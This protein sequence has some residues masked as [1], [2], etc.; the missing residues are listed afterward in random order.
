M[1]LP[2]F[3]LVVDHQ[4]LVP[5]LNNYTLDA[6]ENPKLQRLK[7]RLSPYV[8]TTMWRKGREHAIPDALSRAPVND[9]AP[10]DEAANSDVKTCSQRT[11]INRIA[12]ISAES[13]RDTCITDAADVH[14]HL[15]DP[16]VEEIRAVAATDGDYTTELTELTTLNRAVLLFIVRGM[17]PLSLVDSCHFT[18]LVKALDPRIELPCRSTLTTVLLP[19]LYE[20]AKRKL[21]SEIDSVDHV[22]L[23]AD[24]W[25][26]ITGDS[27]VTVIHFISNQLKMLTRALT[28]SVMLESHT[29]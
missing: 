3:T 18:T 19:N 22:A 11:I 7:E 1:G 9:P 28:T 24:G 8:F 15:P 17:H 29:S 5:I 4:A 23:T 2:T 26:S 13:G 27:Y 14:T 12:H 16:L 6:V 20:E 25:T 10:D 21:Q